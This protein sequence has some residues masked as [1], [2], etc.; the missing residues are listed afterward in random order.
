MAN[1]L[2]CFKK[3]KYPN[4]EFMLEEWLCHMNRKKMGKKKYRRKIIPKCLII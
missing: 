3:K 1:L 4:A 2:P